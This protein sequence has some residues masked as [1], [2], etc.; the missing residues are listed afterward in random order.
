MC[1]KNLHRLAVMS[2]NPER[3]YQLRAAVKPRL[4][5][6]DTAGSTGRQVNFITEQVLGAYTDIIGEPLGTGLYYNT[7]SSAVQLAAAI[8]V[9]AE[10]NHQTVLEYDASK[11][12]LAEIFVKRQVLRGMRIVDLGCGMRP[13]FAMTAEVL[14]AKMY[15]A[16][17]EP[18]ESDVVSVS[19]HDQHTVVNLRHPKA[20]D[21][22]LATTGGSVDLVTE[23]IIGYVPWRPNHGMPSSLAIDTIAERLLVP[24]GYLVTNQETMRYIQ[25]Q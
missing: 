7:F 10:K 18:L 9:A 15:T 16:D 19:L 11:E 3:V 8:A 25:S 17:A 2:N 12:D 21:T 6:H 20:A 22:L 24:G 14:G 13:S 23:S 5:L 4:R 1:A